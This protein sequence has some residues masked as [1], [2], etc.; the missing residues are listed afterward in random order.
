MACR[1][2]ARVEAVKVACPA[3]FRVTGAVSGAE[4]SRKVTVPVAVAVPALTTVAV[5]VTDWPKPEGLTLEVTV[6]VVEFWLEVPPMIWVSSGE[7]GMSPMTST[8]PNNGAPD[9]MGAKMAPMTQVLLTGSGEDTTP[10]G[11]AASG[12]TDV[13]AGSAAAKTVLFPMLMALRWSVA[14]P[15]FSTVWY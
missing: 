9:S 6:V 14:L 5:K 11:V 7:L 12:E 4:P 2:T 15:S 3:A 1:P 8:L 10:S 13:Q